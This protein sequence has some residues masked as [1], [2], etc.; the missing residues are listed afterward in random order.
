MPANL[1]VLVTYSDQ[2]FGTERL[3]AGN[4]PSFSREARAFSCFELLWKVRAISP[5]ANQDD[6]VRLKGRRRTCHPDSGGQIAW[7]W[8]QPFSILPPASHVR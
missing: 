1:P 7:D 6:A 2:W 8:A 5:H 4:N 3:E